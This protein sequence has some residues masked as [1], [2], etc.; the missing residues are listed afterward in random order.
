MNRSPVPF[1]ARGA[2]PRTQRG[3][4]L[5]VSLVLLVAMTVVGIATLA[6]TR[7]NERIA[8][9][10]QQKSVAFEVAESAIDA[11]WQN[12]DIVALLTR[13]GTDFQNPGPVNRPALDATLSSEFDQSYNGAA[14]VDLQ[15]GVTVQYCGEGAPIRGT[16]LDADTGGAPAQVGMLFDVNGVVDV[17]GSG[18][19]ADHVQRGKRNAVRTGR[20]GSCTTPG[21]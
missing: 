1:V 13:P 9:N 18:A 11:L 15:A 10:A 4:A 7:L 19:R 14:S 21:L 2:A 8:G 5:A 6:G 12:E 16:D 17:L 3:V 20:T